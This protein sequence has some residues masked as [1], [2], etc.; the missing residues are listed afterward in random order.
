MAD[1]IF[2]GALLAMVIAYTVIA[3]TVIKAP[4]QYDPLGPETWPRIL[5]L[6]AIPC[7]LYVIVRPDTGSL[8]LT[9]GTLG[10][11]AGVVALLLAYA[12]LFEPL[13]FVLATWAFCLGLALMLGARLLSAVLFGG[14]AGIVGYG[15]CTVLLDLNLPAGVL[16]PIL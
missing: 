11:I 13:G 1:R 5:G 15:V 4:F 9:T 7:C 16:E 14:V 3:F 8:S 6:V 2:A 12:W 10:R